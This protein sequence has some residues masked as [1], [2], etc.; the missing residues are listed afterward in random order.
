LLLSAL[1]G[2]CS[3][4]A[5]PA[6][7]PAG[8]TGSA[9]P[10]AVPPAAPTAAPVV[11]AQPT[12][13]A[14]DPL[15][16]VYVTRNGAMAPMWIAHEAGIFARNGLDSEMIYVSSGT[17]GMQ[18]LLAKEVDIGVIAASAAVAAN[19]SG[20]DAIYVGAIQRTFGLWIYAQ[21]DVM[22]A[23]DLRDKR[24]AITRRNSTT[25]VALG[26]YLD[27]YGLAID[28]DVQVAE[29]GDQATM[30]PALATGAIQAAVLS[31]PATFEA[32]KQGYRELADLTQLGVEYPQ[33][34]LTTTRTFATAHPDVVERFLRSVYEGTHRFKTDRA[35]AL[36]V[37]AKYLQTDQPEL[38]ENTYATYAGQLV[39]DVPRANYAGTRTI[40]NELAATN[41]QARGADPARFL[42]LT[43]AEA[44][45]REGLEAK[46]YG[47]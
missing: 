42:D 28:R 26:Y 6:P 2:A 22:T 31:D 1:L 5:T 40:L 34:A 27:R 46:L 38:L 13:V 44:L 19:L 41:E 18:A 37:M 32:R 17:L 3:A 23:A 36:E 24:V 15:R 33:S 47:R 25:D 35:L 9:P 16:V 12:R 30:V 43:F 21:P 39:Q 11:A 20:A 7:Q 45:D 29:A 14:R 4:A 10:P 8:G